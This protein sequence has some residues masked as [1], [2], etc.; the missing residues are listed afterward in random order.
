M[1]VYALFAIG[2]LLM[3]VS[4]FFA[5]YEI[6]MVGAGVQALAWLVRIFPFKPYSE[7]DTTS[8]E[9]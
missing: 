5:E 9:M 8:H 6:L 1:G 7:A 4:M 2:S 3:A